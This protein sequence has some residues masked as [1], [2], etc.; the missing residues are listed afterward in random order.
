MKPNSAG[1]CQDPLSLLH[2]YFIRRR[3]LDQMKY[4][5]ESLPA[6][7][8]LR[9]FDLFSKL[10]YIRNRKENPRLARR[11]YL[12]NIRTLVP[13]GVE[14]GKEDEK[15]SFKI[16]IEVFDSLIEHFSVNDFDAS[17]SI[18]PVDGNY[19]AIDGAHRVATLAFYGT[20]VTV[21]R[22]D[23]PIYS[24]DYKLFL[25]KGESLYTADLTALEAFNWLDDISVRCIWPDSDGGSDID[26]DIFYVREFRIGNGT[27]GRLRRAIDFDAPV[28]SSR[29]KRVR[30]KFVFFRCH[31]GYCDKERAF[32]VAKTVLSDEG[33]SQWYF[34]TSFAY[35][36]ALPFMRFFDWSMAECKYLKHYLG[37]CVGG[38]HSKFLSFLYKLAS[39]LLVRDETLQKK[40]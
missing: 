21:C 5:V 26:G 28:S 23:K 27:Y 7:D 15:N 9:R 20:D 12:E 25:A 16:F 14:W 24:L 22:F 35:G 1:S 39:P 11:V 31:N 8:L 33:R 37:V 10:F 29:G 40:V 17:V 34:S 13:L 4:E 30:V 6:R 18:V 38:G 36:M 19:V 3:H 2:P 32:R